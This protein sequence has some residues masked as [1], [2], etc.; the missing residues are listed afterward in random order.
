MGF[1]INMSKV[2][3]FDADDTLWVNEPL[4]R[5]AE[6]DFCKLIKPFLNE[7]MCAKKVFENMMQN[8][9]LYGYGV[10]PFTLS[11][12]ETSITLSENA[13]PNT[14]I[15]KIIEIGKRMISAKPE[16]IEG[17]E[18]VLKKLS[19]KHNYKLI[20]AT[21]GDLLDQEQKIKKSGLAH[22][23]DYVEVMSDKKP[24]NYQKLLSHLGI[25]P[26]DFIMIGNS[27]KSDVLPVLEIG[28]AAFHIPFH[29]TWEHE[30]VKEPVVH[31]NFKELK[32]IL[33]LEKYL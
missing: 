12:I 18:D 31:P 13:I 20:I 1:L 26:Q 33:E 14:I 8:L 27:V 17:V 15:L 32:S 10:R 22:Y 25:L 6:K 3:A 28:G 7:T 2:I 29:T 21:K 11:L 19:K 23:F 9:P 16:L 4:F 30:Q 24:V 5:N